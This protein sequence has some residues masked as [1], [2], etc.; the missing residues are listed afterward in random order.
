MKISKK[1]QDAIKAVLAIAHE[2]GYGNMISH[3]R[4]AMAKV[5]MKQI[6]LDEEEAF[7]ATAM[8]P[9]PIKMHDDI[10]ERGEWDETG[11]RYK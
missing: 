6:G 9:Y 1:E 2:W 3:L 4:T 5:V 7:V 10:V 8:S 11:R